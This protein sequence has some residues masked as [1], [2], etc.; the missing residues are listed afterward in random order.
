MRIFDTNV[1]EIK[2]KTLKEVIRSAYEGNL[3]SAA[4]DIPKKLAP[5]PKP[6]LRCCIYK[7][8]AILGERVKL[9]MGGDRDNPNVV[10]VIREACDECPVSG[11][12]VTD[13]CR[14]CL[15]HRCADECPKGAITI[16][17]HRAVIDKEKC[18]ECGKC[19]QVCPYNALIHQHR[20]CMRSCK[21]NAISMDADKK[22]V[23]DND[24]CVSCGA[25]VYQCP[26]GAIM[27]KSYVLD[28]IDILKKSDGNK[29][30]KVYA[31]IAPSIVS[32][33][34]Y[35]KIEQVVTGIHEL[36]FHQVVEA[37]LGADITLYHESNEWKEK[38]LMTTSCCPS[39]VKY[40][41]KYFPDMVNLI[42]HSVSPMVETAK[43]IKKVDS[44]AKTVFIGPCVSKKGE[45]KLDKAKDWID[46]VISFEE[47]QAF[48]DARDINVTVLGETALDNASFYGR[49]FAKSGGI[50]QGMADVAKAM[51]IEGVKPVKM[52][53]LEQCKIGLTKQKFG[54]G[55]GNFYEG[56][57]CVGGCLNGPLCL[58]HGP[59]NVQDVD[60]YGEEAKEKDIF[61]SVK[62]Y[63]LNK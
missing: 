43:L 3:Q 6:E 50:A 15:F 51:G 34:K 36:G 49:I 58:T 7:E 45:Y 40:I 53:G 61:N 31:I 18:I 33:F 17:N 56:M 54:R 20:P 4:L 13:A 22:A 55:D 23:I 9:A 44:T 24:K 52:D 41:E 32:Q 28:A 16:V 29:N 25:C 60:R 10:E 27:D 46:C 12:L 57:A 62:L 11:I 1:Q 26:F 35:A 2:Y 21:V 14:G 42:S 5:G 63:E 8:R 39:F 48:L 38:G 19:T 47:L 30:Y 59:K 37:A